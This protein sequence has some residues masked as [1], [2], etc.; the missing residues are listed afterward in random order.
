MNCIVKGYYWHMRSKYFNPYI[1]II[2][3]IC[4]TFSAAA[5]KYLIIKDFPTFFHISCDFASENCFANYDEC[6]TET[7][8]CAYYYKVASIAD[9]AKLQC[10]P[11]EGECVESFCQINVADCTIYDCG[12]DLQMYGIYDECI[13]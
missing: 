11:D 1:F 13:P 5:Y 3:F 6:E 7:D 9:S 2:L 12:T 4:I 8:E 10:E